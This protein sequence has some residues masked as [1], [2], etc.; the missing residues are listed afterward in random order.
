MH[1]QVTNRRQPR[2]PEASTTQGQ[3]GSVL[4]TMRVSNCHVN[5]PKQHRGKLVCRNADQGVGEVSF[6]VTT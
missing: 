4:L 3:S 1:S 6:C 2:Q 5:A